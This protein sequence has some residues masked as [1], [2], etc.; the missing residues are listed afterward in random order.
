MFAPA[1]AYLG[2]PKTLSKR[3][4]DL[5]LSLRPSALEAAKE[6][7]KFVDWF[8]FYHYHTWKKT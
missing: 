2:H 8:I 7:R 1:A 6:V 5:Q 4:K 3:T